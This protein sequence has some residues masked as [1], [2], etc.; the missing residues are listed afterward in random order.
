MTEDTRL[1]GL[2][3]RVALVTGA[4]SAIGRAV[5]LGLAAQVAAVAASGRRQVP[6]WM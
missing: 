5:A 2:A 1:P 6:P 3:G 4:T